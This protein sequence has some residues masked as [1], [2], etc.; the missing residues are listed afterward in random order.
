VRWDSARGEKL[1]SGKLPDVFSERLNKL[2]QSFLDSLPE[3]LSRIDS[4][5]EVIALES[6]SLAELQQ[7]LKPLQVEAHD[8]AGAAGT[9]G[10]KK[11]GELARKAEIACDGLLASNGVPSLQERQ[12]IG[13]LLAAIRES[14]THC[15]VSR[16]LTSATATG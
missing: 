12:M 6:S 13:E 9:F 10:F 1:M 2:K 4:V 14:G 5:S 8:L 7:A 16:T 3:R 15:L 11:L